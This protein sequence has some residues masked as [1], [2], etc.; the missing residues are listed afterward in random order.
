MRKVVDDRIS[1]FNILEMFSRFRLTKSDDHQ[2]F[3][4]T[5]GRWWSSPR[6]SDCF[7]LYSPSFDSSID[8]RLTPTSSTTRQSSYNHS[9][10][11]RERNQEFDFTLTGSYVQLM[12]RA[13]IRF[14][15]LAAFPK[16]KLE[17]FQKD[18]RS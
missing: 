17:Y 15:T 2:M 3:P 18:D 6:S 11:F 10:N 1:R 14:S 8:P 7:S 12:P 9:F 4:R 13:A 16:R 5:D